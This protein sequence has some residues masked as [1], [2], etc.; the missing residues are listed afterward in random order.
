MQTSYKASFGAISTHS[1]LAVV[2][3]FAYSV[4]RLK[5]IQRSHKKARQSRALYHTLSQ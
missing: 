5:C 4:T 1:R 2:T 3:N